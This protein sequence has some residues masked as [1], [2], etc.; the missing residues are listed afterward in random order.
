MSIRLRETLS[1]ATR[2]A[3]RRYLPCV[4]TRQLF[5]PVDDSESVTGGSRERGAQAA[6]R[7]E[8]T[9]TVQQPPSMFSRHVVCVPRLSTQY[10]SR[11][12]IGLRASAKDVATPRIKVEGG[13]GGCRGHS[14]MPHRMYTE[15][16]KDA[17]R[18]LRK[19]ASKEIVSA[20]IGTSERTS[21]STETA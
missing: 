5:G 17:G 10:P 21:G 3:S 8:G 13:Q 18:K 11:K 14:N 1:L 4:S 6:F 15:E 16:I 12:G 19:K 9:A 20:E 7:P 2:R